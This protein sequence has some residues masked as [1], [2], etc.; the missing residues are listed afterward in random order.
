MIERLRDQ[1]GYSLVEVMVAIM[2]LALAILPMVS[3]FDAGLRAAVLGGNY[4]TARALANKQLERVQS[5]S[6]AAAQ[7]SYPSPPASGTDEEFDTNGRSLYTNRADPDPL[8]DGF[9]Y[10]V[11]KQFMEA[12]E[13]GDTVFGTANEDN[14]LMRVTVTVRW[15]GKRYETNGLKAR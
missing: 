6:Y 4:D 15:D 7:N 11:E 2:I 8:F 12:P 5:L 14:G 3:M 10:D 1:S 13:P 9:T